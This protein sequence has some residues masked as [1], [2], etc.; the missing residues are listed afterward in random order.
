VLAYL[1]GDACVRVAAECGGGGRH[2]QRQEHREPARDRSLFDHIALVA[3]HARTPVDHAGDRR[4]DRRPVAS[5]PVI[6]GRR[7]PH[8]DAVD[9]NIAIVAEGEKIAVAGEA[10]A[11]L[12]RELEAV[13]CRAQQ[14][15]G[16]AQRA[17]AKHD[18]VGFDRAL[19]GRE[20]AGWG[21]ERKE[22]HPPAAAAAGL[23]PLQLHFAYDGGAERGRVR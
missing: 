15:F 5:R 23:D 4:P 21:V 12:R 22:D 10:L 3:R 2:D 6:G 13:P 14:D 8:T 18:D 1:V 7:A 11:E 17:G 19:L 20:A 16:R 9:R